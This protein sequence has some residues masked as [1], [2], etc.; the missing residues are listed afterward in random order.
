MQ[1]YKMW[2]N[3]K[4]V[5][6]ES[7]KTYPVYNPAT[8]EEIAQIPVA[9]NSD[10]EKAVAAARKAFPVWSQ[11]S[12]AERSQMALKISKILREHAKELGEVDTLEHG[13]PAKLAGFLAADIPEWFDWAAYTHGR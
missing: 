1:N 7:G 9:G 8:G 4:F 10:I 2:I 12:Q 3:G 13:T 6:S 11:K 5:E